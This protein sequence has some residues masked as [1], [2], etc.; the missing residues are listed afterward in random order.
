[1]SARPRAI[2][3]SMRSALVVLLLALAGCTA[4]PPQASGPTGSTTPLAQLEQAGLDVGRAAFC[5]RIP[6]SAVTAALGREPAR[7]SSWENGD[8]LP[9]HPEGDVSHEYGCSWAAGPSSAAAWVFAPPVT[10][11]RARQL[12]RR[13]P[14]PKCAP[15][16]NAPPFGA[17]GGDTTCTLNTDTRLV[18]FRGLFGDAW[19]TCRLVSLPGAIEV[20]QRAAD[21]CAEVLAAASQVG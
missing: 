6:E 13:A 19:V 8:P 21:W 7:A 15:L 2:V 5:D 16:K 4:D 3:R 12:I 17:P 20:E 14:G 11:A 9:D 18:E 10:V 1:M